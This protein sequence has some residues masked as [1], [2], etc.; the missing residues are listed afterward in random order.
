[1]INKE[2]SAT[3]DI[4]NVNTAHEITQRIKSQLLEQTSIIKNN[5]SFS[6]S[7]LYYNAPKEDIKKLQDIFKRIGL[8]KGEIDGKYESIIAVVKKY[9]ISNNIVT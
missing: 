7:N 4:T 3:Q 2:I 9:Q 6:S 5:V 8:Y 1:L